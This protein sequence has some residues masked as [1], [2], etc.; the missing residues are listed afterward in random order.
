MASDIP[1]EPRVDRIGLT[2]GST[3]L[4]DLN[5]A[6]RR[7]ESF[8]S[9]TC[10]L[11]PPR[12]SGSPKNETP[13]QRRRANDGQDDRQSRARVETGDRCVVR[14]QVDPDLPRISRRENGSPAAPRAMI[15]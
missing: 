1:L 15:H 7:L 11:H 9:A 10:I 3:Q 2:P 4:G 12:S 14:C 5:H 6:V 8:G 13:D